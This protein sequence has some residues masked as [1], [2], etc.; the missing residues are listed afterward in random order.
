M[1]SMSTGN[2]GGTDHRNLDGVGRT[3]QPV[4]T[5]PGRYESVKSPLSLNI[6]KEGIVVFDIMPGKTNSEPRITRISGLHG[7]Q[8]APSGSLSH[9]KK[10]VKSFNPCNL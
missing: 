6:R 3:G 8:K 4:V 7:L 9:Q 1:F 2:G 10:T 5:T